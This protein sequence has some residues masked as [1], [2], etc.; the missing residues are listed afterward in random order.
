M[1]NPL[2]D[3]FWQ[4]FTDPSIMHTYGYLGIFGI[5]FLGSLLV[6]VPMPYFFLVVAA[7]VNHMFDPTLVGVVSAVGATIAKVVIF[8]ASYTGSRLM[9][10]QTEKRLRPF[11][12]LVSRYGGAAAFL[13]ALTPLPDDLIYIPLGLARYSLFRFILATLT[14]K[15]LFTLAISWGSRLSFD[16]VSFLIEG[17]TDPRGALLVGGAFVA[18][19]ILTVYAIMKLD[20]AK[21]LGRWFPWTLDSK[22]S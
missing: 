7:S 17:I 12:K 5:S 18:I 3:S 1:E 16:Y 6:F 2:L 15:I 21:V 4:W 14:G 13:A 10:I 22:T 9:G 11:M 20:W 19:A 8:E